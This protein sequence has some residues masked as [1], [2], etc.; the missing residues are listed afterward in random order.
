MKLLEI[1][2]FSIESALTAAKAGADRLELCENY[3]NGGTTPS[4]GYLKT[5]RAK[6]D[7]PLFVMICPRAGD[8]VYTD[9][10]FTAMKAD[11]LLC[12]E[13]GF[14]GI[15]IGILKNDGSIDTVRT[16]YL[17]EL[18][19]PM[20]VTFHRAFDRC[21]APLKAMEQIIECGCQRILTSG[22]QPSALQGKNL[23]QQLIVAAD[24]RITIVPGGGIRSN[25]V[26]DLLLFTGADEVHSSAKKT[27][28]SP[29]QFWVEAMHDK[30]ERIMAD[31]TEISA[32]LQIIR[33]IET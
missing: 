1:A 5:V 6:L 30:N 9:A 20:E 14:D 24:H 25:Y 17:I 28:P 16:K 7:L 26:E 13:M 21:K 33:S 22:Q 10:E 4:Y 8:F 23:I 3:D 29:M 32:M 15:V 18:A 2:V 27:A 12:K 19:Y 31:A 11:V